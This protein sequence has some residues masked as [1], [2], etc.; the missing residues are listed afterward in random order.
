MTE[1]PDNETRRLILEA[2][3][4]LFSTRGYSAVKLRDIAT[5]VNVKHGALYYYWLNGISGGRT[6]RVSTGPLANAC[7][8]VSTP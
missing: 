4:S 1:L 2:A 3:E 5:A 8:S 7:G 6:A